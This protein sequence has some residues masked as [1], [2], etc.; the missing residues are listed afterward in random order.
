M[1]RKKKDIQKQKIQ[2]PPSEPVESPPLLEEADPIESGALPGAQ[3]PKNF[4]IVGIGASA[5]GLAAFEAFFSGMPADTDPGMAFVLVQHLAPDHK[6]ILSELVRRYTRMQ[7]YEV[8]DGM[9]V[10]P[11]CTYIIP[12]NRDMAFLNGALQLLE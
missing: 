6:S 7:V 2:A 8:E 9:T 4:P 1:T 12:P 11:N 3:P 5:G 10:Q